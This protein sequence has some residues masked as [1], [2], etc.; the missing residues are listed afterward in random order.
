MRSTA[1]CA[2]ALGLALLFTTACRTEKDP[3]SHGS[4]ASR[5]KPLT[6]QFVPSGSTQTVYVPVYSSIYWGTEVR[7]DI[8]DLTATLSIR[9]VSQRYP[10]IVQSVR[11]F[12]SAGSPV[13]D[14]VRTPSELP[15]LATVEFVVQRLDTSGGPGANFLVQWTGT[16]GMN[17]PLVEAVMVGQ[18]GNAGISFTSAGRVLQPEP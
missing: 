10:V 3:A 16:P 1:L 7:K 5:L 13:R 8:V 14:Y 11:Y 17:A 12:D 15:P 6:G 4:A 2:L 9:N 18:A